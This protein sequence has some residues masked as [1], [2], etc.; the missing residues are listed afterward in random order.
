MT[1]D[2]PAS[3]GRS[4]AGLSVDALRAAF[5]AAPLPMAVLDGTG[6]VVHANPALEGIAGDD[7]VAV[8]GRELLAER[9]GDE[10]RA[11][12]DRLRAGE[13]TVAHVQTRLTAADGSTQFISLGLCALPS[14]PG[15]LLAYVE[16]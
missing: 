6:A 13:L 9:D 15:Y 4:G 3:T 16:D 8:A 12:V 2:D 7:A 14:A 11:L 5:D 10:A 1:D